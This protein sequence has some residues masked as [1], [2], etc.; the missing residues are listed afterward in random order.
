MIGCSGYQR[1]L[2]L[3]GG[4]V[5]GAGAYYQASTPRRPGLHLYDPIFPVVLNISGHI[6]DG[7]LV[8]NITSD[9]FTNLDDIFYCPRQESLSTRGLCK[10]FKRTRVPVG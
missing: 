3:Q 8:A 5:T 4:V 10:L 1:W 7:V 9:S 2:R 6:S